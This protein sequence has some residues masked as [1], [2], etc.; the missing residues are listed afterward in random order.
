M[1]ALMCSFLLFQRKLS[2]SLVDNKT[3]ARAMEQSRVPLQTNNAEQ[4]RAMNTTPI[5]TLLR[6]NKTDTVKQTEPLVHV[7]TGATSRGGN[8]TLAPELEP[9]AA[10]DGLQ[11]NK[12]DTRV[13]TDENNNTKSSSPKVLYTVF[14]GRKN[15]LMLQEPYWAEMHRLG[16]IEEVHLW[17]YT[18]ANKYQQEN[19]EYLRHVENKYSFVTIME[20][21]DVEMPE[22]YWF[23]KNHSLANALENFGNGRA[24]FR[25]PAERWYAEYYRYYSVNPY[26]GVII[27]A[28]DDIVY[29][30]STMVKPYA[31]Y[32]WNHK[33]I[34]LLSASVVNQGLCAHYQQKHGAIPKELMDLPLPGNGMGD[35][36][37]NTTHALMLHRYFLESEEN[38]GKF[39]I[40]EPEY[41]PFSYTINVNFIAIRGQDFYKTFELIQ[42][43]L[44]E[45]NR[46][47]DEGAIT[48]QGIR[49]RKYVEG[50]YLPL[51]VAHATFGVQRAILQDVLSAYV[52]YG[53]TECKDL[54][55]DLLND[56]VP[57]ED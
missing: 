29:V 14:C 11:T 12:T 22:T 42:D 57:Q 38:R 8:E 3:Q 15:R 20:P 48:W 4:K 50:I 25:W 23:D 53:K 39:F 19:L 30:N 33:D 16:A 41:Y 1:S 26:D 32:L 10:M 18:S 2:D 7:V 13:T 35:L 17:N 31:E 40:T 55:G 45:Q 9:Q 56:W 34:F 27:K 24:R 21:S 51:V 46:Y 28:D 44:K 5:I 37:D 49:T 6:R 52:E 43:M 47:Y 54:Y 36:H